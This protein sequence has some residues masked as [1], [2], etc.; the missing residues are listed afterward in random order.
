[1]KKF[2]LKVLIFFACVVVMDLAFGQFFSFLRTHAKGGSTANCEYIANRATDDIVILGSSR[3]THHY[4]PQIIEDSLGVTC[5]NC[6]EEG[7]GV[8]LAYGRL[9]MLTNRYKPKMIIYEIT[10][11][12]DYGTTEPNNKYL[13]Y[14]RPYY[15]NDGIKDVFDDF[16]DELF[17]IKMK[18][19][20]YQ[21][22]SRLLPNLL[23]IIITRDNN[24][25]YEPLYGR[26]KDE[27]H[28]KYDNPNAYFECDSLKLE[29][30][31]KIIKLAKSKGIPIFF[32]IS[33]RYGEDDMEAY[34]PAFSLCNKYDVPVCN[35]IDDKDVDNH[36]Q[37]FQDIG[38]LN[39]AG[40]RFYTNK[41]IQEWIS[42]L[43]TKINS[44]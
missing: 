36:S 10:P 34:R 7:N 26:I 3:A 13:G 43:I 31:E 28:K 25:G 14:L 32:F 40:A 29:Y 15:D 5:Y 20:M 37:Y 4:V 2:L 42:P 11:S 1:M 8:V 38:H 18:S 21:N 44:D 16:D 35:Y 30:V 39:D 23:D 12:Y 33:P 27:K 19:R 17:R 24:K 22:T 6:G 9:K 41:V